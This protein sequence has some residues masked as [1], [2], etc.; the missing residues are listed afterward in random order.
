MT[1]SNNVVNKNKQQQISV[2]S[3]NS[4]YI[5]VCTYVYNINNVLTSIGYISAKKSK[6]DSN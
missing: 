6:Y 2:S 1:K 3:H 5:H 4:V